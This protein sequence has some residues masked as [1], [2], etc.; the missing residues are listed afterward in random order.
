MTS[1]LPSECECPVAG[2]CKR[3]QINKLKHWH[4]LCQTH[5]DYFEAWEQGRGPGQPRTPLAIKRAEQA[6][7]SRQRQ[8]QR[9]RDHWAELHTKKDATPEWFQ[10]WLNRVPNFGCGCKDKAEAILLLIPPRYDDWFAWSVEFHNAINADRR[11][12]TLEE[13]AD[14]W[15]PMP[16][17]IPAGEPSRR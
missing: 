16:P 6:E 1:S 2:Y 5:I 9:L 14:R 7:L 12:W 8:L 15:Q 11:P 4:N 10:R 13:A 17:S 3:H